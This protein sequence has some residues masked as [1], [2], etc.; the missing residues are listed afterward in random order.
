M[1]HGRVL[2]LV[3]QRFPTSRMT[4]GAN[5]RSPNRTWRQPLKVL[6]G[7]MDDSGDSKRRSLWGR[8]I[9]IGILIGVV[10]GILSGLFL[11]L[12]PPGWDWFSHRNDP[13]PPSDRAVA[14]DREMSVIQKL[15]PGGRVDDLVLVL[16][17]PAAAQSNDGNVQRTIFVLE[18]SAVLAVSDENGRVLMTSVTSL[19][20]DFRPSFKLGN[21]SVVT[22]WTSKVGDVLT[23][24][25]MPTIVLGN[26]G[27]YQYYF[28]W[29]SGPSHATD[30]RQDFYGYIP[31]YV[32][33]DGAW[34]LF[35]PFLFEPNGDMVGA[36]ESMEIPS[37]MKEA[38]RLTP[39]QI[40]KW[41]TNPKAVT[42]REGMP[43]NTV[44]FQAAGV[45][46]LNAFP[47]VWS[48]DVIPYL[49]AREAEPTPDSTD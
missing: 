48:T 49:E 4:T 35:V 38:T 32:S 2:S 47:A 27:N 26:P 41:L 3:W 43:V 25:P 6:S 10:A 12:A 45:E 14:L 19:S 17:R 28:E 24:E 8:D 31:M 20:T 16:G 5:R 44:G 37:E 36:G 7:D 39:S 30:F 18:F 33:R 42:F 13:A 22:L 1:R 46:A 34:E 23:T 29:T 9:P 11:L 15:R 40:R 21:G